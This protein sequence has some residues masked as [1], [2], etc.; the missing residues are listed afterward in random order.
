MWLSLL[1]LG[2]KLLPML[3]SPKGLL[4]VLAVAGSLLGLLYVG[5]LRGSVQDLEEEVA[6]LTARKAQIVAYYDQCQQANVMHQ[7][8]LRAL[9]FANEQLA[10]SVKVDEEERIAAV[11]AATERALRAEA[12]LRSTVR[13]L[14][15]MRNET[16][17]CKALSQIDMGDVCPAV[18]DRLR[19]HAAGPRANND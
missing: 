6:D 5:H 16:P 19:Q 9:E 7:R 2:S 14:E 10:A 1:S 12:R 13:S 4:S 8:N 11:K 3:R 17:D 15:D 18:V